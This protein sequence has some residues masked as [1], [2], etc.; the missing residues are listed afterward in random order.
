MA[1]RFGAACVVLAAATLGGCATI[2]TKSDKDIVA[3]RAQQ[4]WDLL[5]KNDFS[6]A[7]QYLSPGSRQIVPTP[8]AYS[9]EFRRNFWSGAK[10]D[11]VSCPTAEACEV[12]VWIE[13]QNL[14]IKMRT[15]VREKWVRQNS[16]WWFVLE[17]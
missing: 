10:V 9:A 16:N 3:E 8:D 15:P 2:G 12:E 7:Y 4:R 14:G 17:R 13:Y 6:G 11:Q 5:V 1:W